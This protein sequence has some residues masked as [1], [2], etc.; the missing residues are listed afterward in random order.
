[1]FYKVIGSKPQHGIYVLGA[2]GF[3]FSS[4]KFKPTPFRRPRILPVTLHDFQTNKMS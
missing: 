2:E 1:M 4:S 3:D